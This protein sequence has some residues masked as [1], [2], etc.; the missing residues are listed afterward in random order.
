VL[1]YIKI[2]KCPRQILSHDSD[3]PAYFWKGQ[4]SVLD[5]AKYNEPQ[6]IPPVKI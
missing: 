5:D 2:I 3:W 1:K 6:S 4:K